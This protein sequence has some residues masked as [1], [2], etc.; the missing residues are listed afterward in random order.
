MFCINTCHLISSTCFSASLQTEFIIQSFIDEEANRI[1]SQ[2]E[3]WFMVW[4]SSTFWIYTVCIYTVLYTRGSG[5]YT[6]ITPTLH[7][8]SDHI[9]CQSLSL[10]TD[11]KTSDSIPPSKPP[12][13]STTIWNSQI[14]IWKGVLAAAQKA[15]CKTVANVLLNTFH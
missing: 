13:K 2:R 7:R 14:S 4:P 12:Q 1:N 8:Q 9:L 5:R 15:I 11:I 6:A 10:P 3:Q